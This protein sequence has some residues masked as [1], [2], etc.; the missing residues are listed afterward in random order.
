MAISVMHLKTVCDWGL[1]SRTSILKPSFCYRSTRDAT[2]FNL[3]NVKIVVTDRC[4]NL[5]MQR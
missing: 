4:M 1:A 5:L 2:D 3:N